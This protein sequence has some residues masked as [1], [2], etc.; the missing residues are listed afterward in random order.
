MRYMP[1]DPRMM[2]QIGRMGIG[3]MAPGSS[4][5]QQQQQQQR[6]PEWWERSL[7]ASRKDRPAGQD[8][9]PSRSPD[10]PDRPPSLLDMMVDYHDRR[11]PRSKHAVQYGQPDVELAT[12]P[13]AFMGGMGAGEPPR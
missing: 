10:R 7:P 12:V 13:W 3:M 8:E 4:P 2:Q 11:R 6:S 5:F 9:D 1:Y